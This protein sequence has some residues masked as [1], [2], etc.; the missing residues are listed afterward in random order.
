MEGLFPQSVID[1][2]GPSEIPKCSIGYG[3]LL[4]KAYDPETLR[5]Q[6]DDW[7]VSGERFEPLSRTLQNPGGRSSATLKIRSSANAPRPNVPSS[8]SRAMLRR[9]ERGETVKT[10]GADSWDLAPSHFGLQICEQT[11]H[12][13]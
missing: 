13:M 5:L 10:S 11:L 6:Q 4:T 3:G 1:L 2:I 12:E 8:K 9:E 7:I